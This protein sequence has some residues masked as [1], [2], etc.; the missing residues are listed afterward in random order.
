MKKIII[1]LLI[2]TLIAVLSWLLFFRNSESPVV[3][4]LRDVLPFGESRGDDVIFPGDLPSSS[5]LD[6]MIGEDGSPKTSLFPVSESPVSGAVAFSKNGSTTVRYVDRATGHIYDADLSTLEKVKIVNNTIPKVYEAY[7]RSDA[8]QVLLR[9]LEDDSDAVEN[10]SLTLTAPRGTSTNALYVVSAVALRGD[11]TDVTVGASSTLFYVLRDNSSISTSSFTGTNIRNLFTSIFRDWK[12]SS[13]GNRL[14]AATRPQ[15]NLS[16]YAYNVNTGNGS[17][18][19]LL[20]P[21]NGLT[22]KAGAEG[23]LIYSY[24]ESGTNRLFARIGSSD[25]EIFPTT[26]ADKCVWMRSGGRVICGIP[27][28]GIEQGE[29][30]RWYKGQSHYTDRIWM[31]EA[32]TGVTNIVSDPKDEFGLSIDAFNLSLSSDE[33]YLIFQNKNDLTLWA[34]RLP[35]F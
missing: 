11:I 18:S 4:T 2:L 19:K 27:V 25:L 10:L 5:I 17:L 12:L 28:S 29:P 24:N 20:G 14:I 8:S 1:S 16:G 7:F 13:A 9:Y 33:N 6:Q 3:E 32:E 23:N 34:L 31:I 15:S 22:V 35:E 30:E 21:L 26:L